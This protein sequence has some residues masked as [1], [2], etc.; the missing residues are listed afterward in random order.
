MTNLNNV[1]TFG[2]EIEFKGV[3]T[4]A[5]ADALTAAGIRSRRQGY[6]SHAIVNYWKVTTDET[7]SS[8]GYDYR[9]GQGTGGELVSPILKG[10]DGLAKLKQVL[11][12]INGLDGLFVDRACGVHVH[13]G[14]VDGWTVNHVKSIYRRYAAF[15]TSFDS[16]MPPS[17]RGDTNRWCG[18]INGYAPGV[19]QQRAGNLNGLTSCGGSKYK[20]INL[21]SL[22]RNGANLGTIEFRQHSGS[23]DYNKLSNW[24]RLLVAFCDQSTVAPVSSSVPTPGF[25]PSATY[26]P[27][28][29]SAAYAAIR[30]QVIKA[31]GTMRFAGGQFWKITNPSGVNYLFTIDQLNECYVGCASGLHWKEWSARH[32]RLTNHFMTFWNFLSMDAPAAT[33]S[34]VT[35]IDAPDQIFAGVDNAIVQFFTK[36][37]AALA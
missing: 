19:A 31:G 33:I 16:F 28:K 35:E 26:Q 3:T 29:R 18:S 25:T 14:R 20:K 23:T 24:I 21:G 34:D 36:R 2:V 9:T 11:A 8:S 4:D 5:M 27:R 22:T 7:V 32:W 1:Y 6:G 12:V 13:L 37:I 30:E 17:R 10:E 15:E